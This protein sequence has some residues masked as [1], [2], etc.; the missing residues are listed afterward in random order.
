[1]LELRG[2]KTSYARDLAAVRLVRIKDTLH[3]GEIYISEALLAEARANPAI[4][5]C[6][7]PTDMRFDAQGNLLD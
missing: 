3:L 2:I 1:M 6:G 5:I 4:E 7:E